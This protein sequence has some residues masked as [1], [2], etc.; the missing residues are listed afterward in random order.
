MGDQCHSFAFINKNASNISSREHIQKSTSHAQ[1]VTWQHRH[2]GQAHVPK[3]KSGIKGAPFKKADFE[4]ALHS[5]KDG[6]SDDLLFLA[7]SNNELNTT[8]AFST[9]DPLCDMILI[10]QLDPFMTFPVNVTQHERNLLQF[11]KDSAA[12][13][14]FRQ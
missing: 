8:P 7:K 12:D 6:N 9:N 13:A 4:V 1:S 10:D 5:T 3:R 11:C 2:R 14:P